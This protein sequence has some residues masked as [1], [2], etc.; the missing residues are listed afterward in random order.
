LC[1]VD[2]EERSDATSPFATPYGFSGDEMQCGSD[3]VHTRERR[4]ATTPVPD[5]I[6]ILR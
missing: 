2:D 3:N 5:T 4:P 1:G 6:W